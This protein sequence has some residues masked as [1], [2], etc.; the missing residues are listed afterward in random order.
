MVVS[1]VI[2]ISISNVVHYTFLGHRF[3]YIVS[4]KIYL[5]QNQN[6]SRFYHSKRRGL[7]NKT[8]KESYEKNLKK[9]NLLEC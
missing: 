1:M 6:Q 7:A 8:D 2:V 9:V 4:A 5:G 3:D